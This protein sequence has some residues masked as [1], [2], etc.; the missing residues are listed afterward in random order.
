[1]PIHLDDL[2]VVSEVAGLRSALIVPCNICPAVTVAARE[3]R[4]F[5]QLHRSFLKSVPF[6]EYI[7]E[8]QSRLE[9]AGVKA[10][11]F[12]SDRIHQWFLCMWTSG[13][14][15][16]LQKQA[17]DYDAVIVLGCES[18]RATVRGLAN[19]NECRIIEGMKVA[20]IMNAKLRFRFPGT[21]SF[22][23]CEIVPISG[24]QEEEETH[25][26]HATNRPEEVA[27][28]APQFC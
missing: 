24:Q 2:D 11:V 13:Q 7:G 20:G 27:A 16:K 21:I 12:R 4:P 23:D 18:A 9:E 5:M 22:E 26:P 17:K 19:T 15:T 28:C 8:M 14:R 1:M 6:E 3:R 10:D 25:R